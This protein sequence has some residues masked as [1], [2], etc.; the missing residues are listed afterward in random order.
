[1]TVQC[2]LCP[3]RCVLAPGQ[4]GDCRIRVNLDGRLHALTYGYPTAVH[5]DPVEKKPLNHFLPGSRTFSL[6]TVG[7]NLHCKN[8]QNWEISQK[9]PEDDTASPLPPE[10]IP[11]VARRYQCLSVAYTYTEPLAYYEYTLDSC[12]RVRDAGLKNVLVTAGYVNDGPLRELCPHVDAANIDLKAFSDAFYREICGATL[13]PVLNTLVVAKSMGVMV[14]VTNL[15][16]PTL[17]DSDTMIQELC[18]WL[19]ANM[20]A[21]TP[22]HFSRFWPH[23]RLRNL[24]PTPAET[25]SK[26][27]AIAQAAGL[28]YVYIGNVMVEDSATTYCPGCRKRLIQRRGYQVLE[29]RLAG[30]RCPDCGTEIYG[31]WP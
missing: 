3:K 15:L 7:C 5:V 28:H 17:N 22:L 29:Q 14:E 24:P 11:D 30:N 20:G 13:A 21:E 12:I 4:R 16:I 8:C 6:A 18:V 2:E 19:K 1:M 31:I 10:S 26:A 23:Y 9:N 25:L 27:R